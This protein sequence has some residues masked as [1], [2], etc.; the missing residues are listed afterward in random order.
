MEGRCVMLNVSFQWIRTTEFLIIY[1]CLWT[2]KQEVENNT[3]L[4]IMSLY[5]QL[6]IIPNG[7]EDSLLPVGL[8]SDIALKKKKEKTEYKEWRHEKNPRDALWHMLWQKQWIW[9][10]LDP[11][12]PLQRWE[13]CHLL[14]LSQT[15]SFTIS[16][17]KIHWAFFSPSKPWMFYWKYA[18]IF[19]PTQQYKTVQSLL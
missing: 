12:F 11:F 3:L 5:W 1:S 17:P 4:K 16:C 19:S 18:Y 7:I 8:A 13:G 6:F 2:S 15:L 10:L 14:Q 9:A